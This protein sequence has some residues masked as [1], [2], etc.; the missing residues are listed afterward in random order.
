MSP[1]EALE[2]FSNAL[3]ICC[4]PAVGAWV[5]FYTP[6]FRLEGSGNNDHGSEQGTLLIL[7]Q[8]LSI[9]YRW[10]T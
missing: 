8:F 2:G 6:W 1:L 10:I 7:C 4:E 9:P 5:I 3:V